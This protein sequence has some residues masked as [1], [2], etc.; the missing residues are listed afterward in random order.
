VIID[1]TT[2]T[3][4]G[5]HLLGGHA[6]DTINIFASAIRNEVSAFDLKTGIYVH[7]AATS[8]VAYML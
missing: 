1:K 6:G 7:P 2:G 3:I 5:A 8:D 4:L